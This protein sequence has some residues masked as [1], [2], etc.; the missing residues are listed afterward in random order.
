MF[1]QVYSNLKEHLHVRMTNAAIQSSAVIMRS[2]ILI[3]YINNERNWGRISIR[4]RTH[5]RHPIPRPNA[6]AV[7]VLCEYLWENWARY[8]GTALYVTNRWFYAKPIQN[9]IR[10][11]AGLHSLG[12][13]LVC[14]TGLRWQH[15]IMCHLHYELY[16]SSGVLAREHNTAMDRGRDSIKTIHYIGLV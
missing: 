15:R 4:C 9:H 13:R 10:I 2:N 7:G 12:R 5:K 8:N 16:V 3:Y 6:W 14:I 11:A 1:Y